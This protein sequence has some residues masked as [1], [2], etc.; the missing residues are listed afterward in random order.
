MIF[1]A[2]SQ[3]LMI[4]LVIMIPIDARLIAWHL[5]IMQIGRHIDVNRDVREIL[6]GRNRPMQTMWI[7]DVWLRW[8]VLLL[9]INC[10]VTIAQGH[11]YS[12]VSQMVLRQN[13][14]TISPKCA[15]RNAT[16]SMTQTY[17]LTIQ[18]SMEIYRRTFLCV[19]LNAHKV[20]GYLAITSLTYVK[21]CAHWVHLEIRTITE[22]VWLTVTNG[23]LW[24]FTLK[25]TSESVCHIARMAHFPVGTIDIAR[26]FQQIVLL[27]ST[28]VI[29]TTHVWLCVHSIWTTSVTLPP[30][31]V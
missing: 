16:I 30:N 22:A 6:M 26:Q 27:D 20:Q 18:D 11:V 17:I 24:Y 3:D 8:H 29:A 14:L 1:M 7:R 5:H 10:M 21:N 19:L 2:T 31:C 9:L 15:S 4:H 23:M 28:A 13:G 25:T 12:N